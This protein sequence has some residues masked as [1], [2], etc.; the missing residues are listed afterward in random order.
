MPLY[1]HRCTNCYSRQAIFKTI[2]Q[3][4]DPRT[5]G[6]CEFAMERILDAPHVAPD[7]TAYDCPITGKWIEGKRAHVENLKQHGCRVYEPG[8][9]E[10][11]VKR[12]AAEEESLSDRIAETAAAT[13]ASWDSR[14]QER[15]ACEL[16]NG[17]DVSFERK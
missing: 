4:D 15:L 16:S 3:R 13:V 9:R 2:E 7:A 14:K 11:R 17:A 10:A 6:I 12:N 1:T 8:E 5:C